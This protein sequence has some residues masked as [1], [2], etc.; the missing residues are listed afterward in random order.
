MRVGHILVGARRLCAVMKIFGDQRGRDVS[1]L[2]NAVGIVLLAK[3][4][5]DGDDAQP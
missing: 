2:D 3:F 1:G 5:L 4:T